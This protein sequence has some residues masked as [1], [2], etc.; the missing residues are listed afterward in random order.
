MDEVD[1]LVLG[2]GSAGC[3]LAS[4]LSEDPRTSVALIEAGGEGA[5]WIV[6]T[7]MA[8]VL[9]LPTRLNNWAYS[10]V[11]QPALGGRIGYQ[12]RG[13]GLGGSSAINAMIY[14]R[15][16]RAD[17]DRWSALG[18]P[19]WSYREVLP[20]FLKSENNESIVDA[21][22]GQGGPLNVA[23]LRTDNPFQQRFL[24][25]ARETQLPLTADFNGERQ[26]GC[27]LYQVTQIGGERCSAARAY[28]R[29]YI[30]KRDNLIVKTRTRA[31]RLLFEGRRAVGA[32]IF[33]RGERRSVR[34]RRETI[35]AMGAF[36]SPQLLMLSGLGDAAALTALGIVPI[37]DL[38]SV[39]ANLH[40]HPDIV[41]GYKSASRDLFGV[42]FGGLAALLAQIARYRRERRGMATS[43]FAEGGG[44]LKT[45]PDLELPDVQLHF[46]VAYVEDH[47]RKIR[48]GHGFTCHVCALRPKSRGWVRLASPDP[49]AAPLIHPNFLERDEDVATLVEGFKLT[50]RLMEAP[51]LSAHRSGASPY[52][53]LRTDE[54]IRELLRRRVDT[55]YHPV[56]SCAMGPDAAHS[57]VDARLRVHGIGALR[58]VDAS[59]MPEIVGG[60]TNAPTIMIAE[61]AAD[62]I[63]ADGG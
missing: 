20:Y 36:G 40:D 17:Y 15:G 11:P 34:A 60:N 54:D 18:N 47:A 43:N 21:F 22:H 58:V 27:G 12:P 25:A 16:H 31:L 13:R 19:G 6:D 56:G 55:V 51:A 53:D 26:E 50:R 7:P 28:L 57:V 49:L 23:D 32:E 62:M 37:A 42:S 24:D 61:K 48:L 38:P 63:K 5:G 33:V 10:T 39:G 30:G 52:A 59:I 14:T 9:T 45:R 1:Y 29:P 44:F 41:L 3:A 2:G 35:V 4:R 46:V 8:A